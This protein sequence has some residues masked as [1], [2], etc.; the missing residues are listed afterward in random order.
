MSEFSEKQ[1]WIID[2]RVRIMIKKIFDTGCMGTEQVAPKFEAPHAIYE[3]PKI[4]LGTTSPLPT[5]Q[6]DFNPNLCDWR[7]QEGEKGPYE[8]CREGTNF[9]LLKS[10]LAEHD[11]KATLEN[12]F[13]WLF[14]KK[15]QVGRKQK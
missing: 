13:Y 5:A 2:E 3:T 6:L 1:L 15:D 4:S 12:V 11:N 14:P 8:A 10:Y 9:A 7:R